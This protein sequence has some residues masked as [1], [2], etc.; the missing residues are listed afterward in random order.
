MNQQKIGEFLKCLR[1]S[2]GMTQEQLAEH[3]CVSTRT[4]SRWETGSNM[5]DV[6]T[7]IALADFYD[8][9][10][11]EIMDGERKSENMDNEERDTLKK[12]AEYVA[13]ENK[14]LKY[15]MIDMMGGAA[16]LLL[17]GSVLVETN[18][19]KGSI[20]ENAYHN[21]MSFSVGT[22]LAV[23]GLNIMYLLGV[24]DKISAWKKRHREHRD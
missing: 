8:V 5:P 24:F 13:E 4:I 15:K 6:E 9:A 20:P 7:L 10:V 3:F 18:A 16:V 21:Y 1:K 23:L 12:V 19:F 14:R 17:F 11:R 2:K 22:A